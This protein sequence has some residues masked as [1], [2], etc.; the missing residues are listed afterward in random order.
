MLNYSWNCLNWWSKQIRI[1]LFQWLSYLHFICIYNK[2]LI[3]NDYLQ[4][5]SWLILWYYV[6]YNILQHAQMQPH[7]DAQTLFEVEEAKATRWGFTRYECPC[8]CCHGAKQQIH[9]VII[10]R[11]IRKY[12]Y[13]IHISNGQWWYA[14]DFV[15]SIW[16]MHGDCHYLWTHGLR[17]DLICFALDQ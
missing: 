4:V 14:W 15:L 6:K 1:I 2:I 17:K 11:N 10:W 16:M 9:R 13:E 7:F 8:M 3:D 12:M 5:T